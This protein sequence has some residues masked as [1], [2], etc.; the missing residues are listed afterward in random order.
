MYVYKIS[1]GKWM[2]MLALEFSPYMY[3][4]SIKGKIKRV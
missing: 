3:A 4:L 1:Y 2:Q